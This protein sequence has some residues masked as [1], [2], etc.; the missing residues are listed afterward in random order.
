MFRYNGQQLSRSDALN[1]SSV[2]YTPRCGYR[3]EVISVFVCY[4]QCTE[5]DIRKSSG[6]R[7]FVMVTTVLLIYAM[8]LVNVVSVTLCSIQ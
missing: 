3:S 6:L 8:A 2:I 4:F 5:F 7:L 1:V